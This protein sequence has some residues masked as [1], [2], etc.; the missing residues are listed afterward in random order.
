MPAPSAALIG[1]A[2]LAIHHGFAYE[3]TLGADRFQDGNLA[4]LRAIQVDVPHDYASGLPSQ[5]NYQGSCGQ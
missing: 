3:I 4:S 2:K 5:A 1:S